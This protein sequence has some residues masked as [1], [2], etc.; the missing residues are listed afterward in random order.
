MDTNPINAL[1]GLMT[2]PQDII[3]LDE[4]IGNMK[5]LDFVANANQIAGNKPITFCVIVKKM[6]DYSVVE[7]AKKQ[8]VGYF[9]PDQNIDA[10]FDS[11]RMAL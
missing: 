1:K 9:I 6:P 5:M 11:V 3:V 10:L 2:K 4:Y 7:E 8:G